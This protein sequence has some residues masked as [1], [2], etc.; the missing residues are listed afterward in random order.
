MA[1]N[2]AKKLE[3]QKKIN[4]QITKYYD[5]FSIKRSRYKMRINIDKKTTT[6]LQF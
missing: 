3:V 6:W 1:S 2:K 5:F 4:S